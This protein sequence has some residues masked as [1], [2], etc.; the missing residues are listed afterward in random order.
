MRVSTLLGSVITLASAVFAQSVSYTDPATRIVYQSYTNSDGISFRIAL[1]Q[2]VSTNYDAILQIVSPVSK[3]WVGFAWGGT[4]VFN[5]LT[6]GWA[7]GAGVTSSSRFA[8]GLNTPGAYD[9]ETLIP[10][11]GSGTNS[12]HW[13]MTVLCKGCTNWTDNENNPYLLPGTSTSVTFAWAVGNSPVYEPANNQSYF[14]VHQ[15]YGKWTHNLNAARN[16]QFQGWVTANAQPAT[17]PGGP[18]STSTSAAPISTTSSAVVAGPSGAVPS[19]CG[20]P[21]PRYNPVL[22]SGWKATKVLGGMTNPRS[23][24][25]DTAGNMLVVQSGRGIS[26]HGMSANGCASDT[27]MLISQNNLNHGIAFSVDGKYLYASSATQV[28]R[29]NYDAASKSVQGSSTVVVKGMYQGIHTTRTLL[30]A[31]HQPNLLLVSHGS[32]S[33]WDYPVSNPT[34]VPRS[35]VKVFDLS[36]APSGGF[37][38]IRDGWLAGYGLRNGVGIAFDNGNM[39]WEVENS[40]DDF[41]RRVNNNNVD[42]HIDNPAEELNYIGDVTKDNRKWFGY[43]TC[44]T[45][46][47]PRQ[48]TDTTFK[49]GD[50]FV[51]AP[52]NTY[53][54]SNCVGS[55]TQASLSFQAHSAPIDLKFDSTS[56]N[57]FIT[58]HGSWNRQPTTGFKLINVPFTKAANG[59]YRPVANPD[60]NQGWEDIMTNPD[61]TRCVGNGPVMSQGCFR[62]AGLGF[63]KSGRLYMTSD[64]T[65][66]GEIWVLGKQ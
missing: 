5:P 20:A 29:W 18:T 42:I 56:S 46:W 47:Q 52:N 4:M 53:K 60:S 37:D 51:V 32:S 44:F 2:E 34:S 35:V 24:V 3:P 11:K 8:F 59:E 39:L 58:F 55:S 23:I 63:D 25:F 27:K 48:F 9:G 17:T 6:L 1:P 7:N 30:I 41:T 45:V 61:V 54:D 40:G 21:N 16:S 10:M 31:P 19:S 43:P 38:W 36:K 66:E 33:N 28:L 57:L 50:Q 49:V 15:K 22:K 13:T 64:T 14:D 26:I 62:P 12:T 65:Q